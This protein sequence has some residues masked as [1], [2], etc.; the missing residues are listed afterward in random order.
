MSNVLLQ[1]VEFKEEQSRWGVWRRYLYESG[2]S[3]QEFKSYATVGGMPLIHYTYGVNPTTGKRDLAKGFLAVGR[4]AC[5]VIAIG[6]FAVG[7]IAIGQLALGVMLGLGQASI[8]WIGIGQLAVGL[9]FGLGQFTVGYIAIGQIAFGYYVL[10]QIG[11]G[12]HVWSTQQVSPA[13]VEF[14]QSL[15]LVKSLLGQ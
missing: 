12:V 13:A 15:P 10:T 2:L 8:G 7:I 11:W 3:Y 4:K 5:G 1:E 9:W 6:Q 14:F